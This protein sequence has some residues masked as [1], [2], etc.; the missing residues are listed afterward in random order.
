MFKTGFWKLAAPC[1]LIVAAAVATPSIAMQGDTIADIVLGEP[2]FS[3][4]PQNFISARG[5]HGPIAVAIDASVVPNRLYVADSTNNRILGYKDVTSLMNGSLADLVIGQPAFSSNGCNTGGL[6]AASLCVPD[7]VAVDA[8][9]NLY[10]TDSEN[11]RVLEYTSPFAGCGSFPCVG[12]PASRVFGQGGSFT[13]AACNTGGISANSLCV[14]FGVALDAAGNLYVSDSG[15]SRVLEY[16]TP[17]TTDTTADKVFGQGGNFSSGS[18]DGIGVSADSLCDPAGIALDGSSDLYIADASNNRV[19][20]Y[21][22]PLNSNTTADTVFGQLGS[23][24]S[25]VCRDGG[26]PSS[27]NLCAPSGVVVDSR[28]N[29]YIADYMDNRVLEYASPLTTDTVADKVVGQFNFSTINFSGSNAESLFAPAGLALDSSGNLYVADYRENRVLQYR[30]PLPVSGGFAHFAIGQ[31][32]LSTNV[33]NTGVTTS[34]SIYYPASVA[35]DTSVVP[36]RLYVAD[37]SNSRVLGW[38]DLTALSNNEPADLVIGQ[39]DFVSSTCDNGGPSASSLCNASDLAVD[40]S[41]NLYVGDNGNARVLEYNTPFAACSSFPCVGGSANL[42][43][44]QSSFTVGICDNGGVTAATMCVPAGLATDSAGNLYVSDATNHRV[45]EFNAPLTSGMTASMVFGQGGSFTSHSCNNGG[46]NAASLCGPNG[47][48]VDTSGNLFVADTSNCRVLEYDSPLTTD[49]VADQVF[50]QP[51]FVSSTCNN[52]GTSASSLFFPFGIGL[53]TSGDL[54]IADNDNNRVLE[55]N[56]PLTNNA[57]NLVFGQSG[58]VT[59]GTCNNG[60]VSASSLCGPLDV[61]ADSNGNIY[62]ADALNGRVLEYDQPLA[63]PT[64]TP[65]ATATATATATDASTATATATATD[66]T[67]ATATATATATPTATPTPTGEGLEELV[68]NPSPPSKLNFGTVSVGTT[69]ASQTATITNEFNDD[70]VDFFATFLM[71]NFVETGSTCS[72]SL[73]PLQSCQVDFACKP[74]T[75]GSII[76]AYAFLY[77]S[78]EIAGLRDGDDYLKIGVA[79]FTCTGS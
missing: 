36:N 74:K 69:S 4:N 43:L 60:G 18:C 25:S 47:L 6:S 67:T 16:N 11:S 50:G 61:R 10:V 32:T 27:S 58:N 57:A 26:S 75:T 24:N 68:V 21:N 23:F 66:T 2:N 79:Q 48:A 12:A 62:I 39:P 28:N 56:N 73:G 29:V 55:Y 13:T 33:I 15:N 37:Q 51:D 52:G 71:A 34:S 31:N 65:T 70:T 40:G 22:T 41:G 72:S 19:L 3:D 1:L 49:T 14:P 59:S 53:D 5:L 42:V 78:V 77:S 17:L 46:T 54:Y 76:G 45:L 8:G 63:T 20:E 38:R 30:T 44:G 35:I 9:G 64:P 7:G